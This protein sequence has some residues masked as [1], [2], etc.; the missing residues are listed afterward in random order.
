MHSIHQCITIIIL[1]EIK[2]TRRDFG[3]F[4]AMAAD[5]DLLAHAQDLSPS[6]HARTTFGNL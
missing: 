1:A 3:F 6:Q 5:H 2:S 4:S